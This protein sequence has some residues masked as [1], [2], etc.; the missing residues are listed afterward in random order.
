[1]L[2]LLIYTRFVATI[3]IILD[4][5]NYCNHSDLSENLEIYAGS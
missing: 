2:L 5:Y 4:S 1:M 3:V